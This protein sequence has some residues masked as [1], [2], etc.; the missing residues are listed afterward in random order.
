MDEEID[1]VGSSTA[2]TMEGSVEEAVTPVSDPNYQPHLSFNALHGAA[3]AA[4]MR[5]EGTINGVTVQILLDSG[6][7]DSFMQPRLAQFLKLLM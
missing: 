3:G 5:F 2:T 4:T 6:S 1:E 7:S